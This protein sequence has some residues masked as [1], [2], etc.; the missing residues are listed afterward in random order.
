MLRKIGNIIRTIILAPFI[1]A[2]GYLF[3]IMPR[4]FTSPGIK[5]FTL[6]YYAHRGLHDNNT[7]APENSINAFE[8]AVEHGYGIELDVQLT[9]DK[10]VVV[11]HDFDLKRICGVDKKIADMTYDELLRYNILDS[12]CKI[13][14]FSEVLKV[15]DGK[16]PIIIEYKLSNLDTGICEIVNEMLLSYNGMYMIESFNPMITYWYKKNR[17]DVV[18]GIL[19]SDYELGGGAEDN[20]R[21]I[22]MM[23]KNLL[24]N[25]LIKPDFIAY[26]CRFYT[27]HS[28]QAC[29]K[30]FKAPSVAW[31]IKSQEELDAR[32]DDYDIFIFEGFIPGE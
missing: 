22:L 31:T 26:D 14:L 3:M 25:W 32:S 11:C 28:R 17:P 12:D 21:I 5:R 6:W 24:F 13:P 20:S 27:N 15:I 4:I 10:K 29:R 23:S 1:T 18:R 2:I 9:R 16:V 30:V 19:A 8:K 7:D